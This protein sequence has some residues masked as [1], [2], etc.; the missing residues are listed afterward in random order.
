MVL[1][2]DHSD[3]QDAIDRYNHYHGSM[4]TATLEAIAPD[5]F[6][7]RFEGPFDRMCCDYDYIEDL[8]MDVKAVA[9]VD[10]VV[11]DIEPVPGCYRAIFRVEP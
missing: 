1:A 9:N 5:Q 10:V 4:A 2:L 6:V 3:L 8:T 11:T 7:I